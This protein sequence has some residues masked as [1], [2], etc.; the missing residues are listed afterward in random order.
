MVRSAY[1]GA[2]DPVGFAP[3][4]TQVDRRIV[5]AAGV[6]MIHMLAGG[7][8][9]VLSPAQ[10]FDGPLVLGAVQRYDDET[11]AVLG[12]LRRGAIQVRIVDN[13]LLRDTA[14]PA[15]R[16]SLLNAFGSALLRDDFEFSSWPELHEH[17]ELRRELA[18]QLARDVPGVDGIADGPLRQRLAALVEI[19][20]ALRDAG[21]PMRVTA[22]PG[23]G[24]AARVRAGLETL[25]ED[26]VVGELLTR[27]RSDPSSLRTRSQW[28]SLIRTLEAGPEAVAKLNGLVNISY[29]GLVRAT[30]GAEGLNTDAPDYETA[31]L[32]AKNGM[33]LALSAKTAELV[34]DRALSGWLTWQ[35]VRR[36]R[37]ELLEITSSDGRIRYLIS[38]HAEHTLE[39]ARATNTGTSMWAHV[40]AAPLNIGGSLLGGGVGVLTGDPALVLAG[41][42]AG[43]ALASVANYLTDVFRER[44]AVRHAAARAGELS[45]RWS[46]SLVSDTMD[47]R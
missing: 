31:I 1:F 27:V 28:R 42:G 33:G 19:D 18:V 34:D 40:K 36:L 21:L 5:E 41:A 15:D 14:D 2:L 13:P 3:A 39:I 11:L 25:P 26:P 7:V 44:E 35:E 12:L 45:D 4:A 30:L 29:N 37:D 43:A 22:P 24:L 16:F 8:T 32:A 23:D 46:P 6:L 20:R 38:R 47:Y 10:A 9:P 17:P